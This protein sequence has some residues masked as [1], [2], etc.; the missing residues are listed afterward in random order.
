MA[1]G[2]HRPV[3]ME[4]TNGL[5]KG[6]KSSIM[7]SIRLFEELLHAQLYAKYR[8]TYPKDLLNRICRF[9]RASGSPQHASAAEERYGKAT[10]TVFSFK[11]RYAIE[12]TK[13]SLT[14]RMKAPR[15]ISLGAGIQT[16]F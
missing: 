7:T 3:R 12:I 14:K 16:Q 9:L 10:V 8:P 13:K 1:K 15:C 6:L 2:C 5:T 11:K 4:A